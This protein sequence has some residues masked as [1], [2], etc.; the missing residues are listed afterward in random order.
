MRCFGAFG[1]GRSNSSGIPRRS[2]ARAGA[3]HPNKT[4]TKR[5]RANTRQAENPRPERGRDTNA[6]RSFS[7]RSGL[8]RTAFGVP[9]GRT[10]KHLLHRRRERTPKVVR[11]PPRVGGATLCNQRESLMSA[12]STTG[13]STKTRED[14]FSV[15]RTSCALIA[16]LIIP[17]A[18]L[19]LSADQFFLK[20]I[21]FNDCKEAGICD[22][23]FRYKLGHEPQEW[24]T[25]VYCGGTPSLSGTNNPCLPSYTT[26]WYE[27]DTGD[28]ITP[29]L[30][31]KEFTGYPVSLF[32][33]VHEYD[34][35]LHSA[36]RD[37]VGASEVA[38]EG[39]GSY[40]HTM[41]NDEGKVTIYFDILEQP[42]FSIARGRP[43]VEAI[44]RHYLGV[45]ERGTDRYDLVGGSGLDVDPFLARF[46]TNGADGLSLV[47]IE[48]VPTSNGRRYLGI[49]REG[50][51]RGAFYVGLRGGA[52]SANFE[53]LKAHGY[54][55]IDFDVHTTEYPFYDTVYTRSNVDSFVTNETN[56]EDML[57]LYERYNGEGWRLQDIEV[58]FL[59]GHLLYRCVYRRSTA[60]SA[61]V[62]S[63]SRER[64]EETW[65]H[66]TARGLKL[67]DVEAFPYG[68]RTAYLSV[69]SGRAN[70]QA[71]IAAR[72][73]EDFEARTAELHSEG[74]RLVD[75][76]IYRTHDEPIDLKRDPSLFQI[77]NDRPYSV[78]LF[79]PFET[80]NLQVPNFT[81]YVANPLGHRFVRGDA[82]ADGEIA[83]IDA[84]GILGDLFLGHEKVQ[85]NDA[86]DANDDGTV[87]LTDAIYILNFLFVGTA[88]PKGAARGVPQEDGSPD[89]LGCARFVEIEE[90]P[91]PGT[92]DFEVDE[93]DFPPIV[94]AGG[95]TPLPPIEEND[96]RP[97]LV[98][99]PDRPFVRR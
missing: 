1:T 18:S 90:F 94:A 68:G 66:W 22:W 49:F 45:F 28:S 77:A 88:P 44:P 37:L 55:L 86:A 30:A 3:S 74:Y 39:P 32:M 5:A 41:E 81:Q 93:P 10:E 26:A 69:F 9:E 29:H 51:Y 60:Q 98:V 58:Q 27:A 16:L 61:F 65:R 8:N 33:E 72:T 63:E 85:C 89:Q 95:V 53:N 13:R 76:E 46:T 75:I 4:T 2:P 36:G 59:R 38:I 56:M 23:R 34:S 12:T 62:F 47:D 80:K 40:Q 78:G 71:V 84:I 82:D 42:T 31:G 11:R 43:H 99:D 79:G 64:F 91:G 24:S 54:E 35:E 48:S 21:E 83:M 14:L 87:A 70:G 96:P 97:P 25:L 67:I 92:R 57:R 6:Q 15:S 7:L 17:L 52:N 20:Q 73:W 19:P 50:G